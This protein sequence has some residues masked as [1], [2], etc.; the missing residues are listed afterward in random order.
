MDYFRVEGIKKAFGGVLAINNFSL[1]VD[2]GTL[3]GIIGP[4]G[5]GKTTL[6]NI[7]TGFLRPNLGKVIFRGISRA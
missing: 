5:C 1:S 3:V 6:A 4:N 2:K 7:V